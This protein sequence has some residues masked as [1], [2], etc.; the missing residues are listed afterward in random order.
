LGQLSG[1]CEPDRVA[2]LSGQIDGVRP[3]SAE[4]PNLYGLELTLWSAKQPTGTERREILH[5]AEQSLGFRT[6]EV[7]EDG[8]YVN[9]ERTVLKGINRHSFWPATGRALD[10]Q[11]NV[12]DVRL[13]R[14]LNFNAVR[15][16]HSPPDPA[17][18]D[19]CDELGLFVLAEFPGWHDAY[20]TEVG[21]QLIAEMLQR[22]Q[23]HPSI[24]LWS[25]GNEGG[26]N[27][28][29]DRE[30]ALH[31]PQ[32][33]PVVHPWSTFGGFATT[34]YPT[35]S[36]L[37]RML[38]DDALE[39]RLARARFGQ[40]PLVLPTEL[41]HA[42]YDGGGA[43]GLQ[44][45]WRLLSA[46]RRFAGAFLWSLFDEGLVRSDRDGELD[47]FGNHAADGILDPW[48][49][50]EASAGGVREIFAPVSA[51]LSGS[52]DE[53][54]VV[55][56]HNG[57]DHL[58]LEAVEVRYAWLRLPL[59]LAEETRVDQLA[60]GSL[61]APRAPPGGSA[62]FALPLPPTLDE[63]PPEALQLI[64]RRADRPDEPP[65]AEA[66]FERDP[67]AVRI[68]PL[69]AAALEPFELLSG[70]PL[71]EVAV[72]ATRI[73]F[74]EEGN[75]VH[76]L[77]AGQASGLSGGHQIR[78]G[79]L[80][81]AP[82]FDTSAPE[83]KSSA[84]VAKISLPTARRQLTAQ[85]APHGFLPTDTSAAPPTTEQPH[86][87][88]LRFAAPGGTVRTWLIRR[89]GWVRLHLFAPAGIA[90][91]ADG[92]HLDL[93]GQCE[94]S[95]AW[96]GRGPFP[97]WGNRRTGAFGSWEQPRR[98]LCRANAAPDGPAT[99]APR[100]AGLYDARWLRLDLPNGTLTVVPGSGEL[101]GIGHVSFP[102]DAR[103]ARAEIP[104]GLTIWREPPE[105]GTKFHPPALLQGPRTPNSI[106]LSVW[107]H[108]SASRADARS[109]TAV[110]PEDS[111]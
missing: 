46:S 21:R 109:P 12:E 98:S 63:L 17:F 8:F 7:R 88:R 30:F 36:G 89:D 27:R 6:V 78:A 4:E 1:T 52:R 40:L 31:D 24:V 71:L 95:L 86:S 37:Q 60:A 90:T 13:L 14:S 82:P 107:L 48:R 26:W 54:A 20:D 10:P 42:L 75:L 105:I 39:Q 18:L 32:Q 47:T 29:L 56:L 70:D 66:V 49:R 58:D 106:H 11:R 96:L 97:V 62:T 43:A 33:R 100:A 111:R 28:T 59:P 41:L 22:D 5:R 103:N 57:Y 81:S 94:A 80:A 85:L 104:E 9:H 91:T 99:T 64:L 84:G 74:D 102:G 65:F 19:A 38:D 108:F 67:P 93:A 110:G 51:E 68:P 35:W 2:K 23:H 55:T 92:L 25:N 15:T 53:P 50:P 79:V 87:L 72:G 44:A 34:H 73:A 76:F 16:A 3:W 69:A 101:L 77:H 45:Y 61:R 83:A